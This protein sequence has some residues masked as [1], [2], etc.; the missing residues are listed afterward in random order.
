MIVSYTIQSETLRFL[1]I[2]YIFKMVISCFRSKNKIYGIFSV[3]EG[4]QR[5]KLNSICHKNPVQNVSFWGIKFKYVM[6]K[7]LK[8]IYTV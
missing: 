2:Q 1:K 7:H 8:H 4:H 3:W 6:Q 5:H